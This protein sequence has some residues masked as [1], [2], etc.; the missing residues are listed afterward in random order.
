M[1]G[2]YHLV[3]EVKT[4]EDLAN[5]AQLLQEKSYFR[6]ASDRGVSKSIYGED[7]DGLEFE[8]M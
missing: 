5:A 4:I 7:P 1:I 8:I 2:L 3:W 6:G